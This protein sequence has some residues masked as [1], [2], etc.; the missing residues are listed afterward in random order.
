MI[1]SGWGI[2]DFQCRSGSTQT[3]APYPPFGLVT[4]TALVVAG[5]LTLLG[6]YNSAVLVSTSNT[7]RASIQRCAMESKLLG[8]IGQAEMEREIERT[9]KQITQRNPS[10]RNRPI[11]HWISM[12]RLY[13]NPAES[14][15]TKICLVPLITMND[16]IIYSS[17]E[18]LNLPVN[19][20]LQCSKMRN[21]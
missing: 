14:I 17:N 10:L 9:V 4:V 21:K 12:K 18:L 19:V 20:L 15:P 5:Y 7:L 11:Y 3:L 1:V 2:L 8:L 13:L 16:E 6:I